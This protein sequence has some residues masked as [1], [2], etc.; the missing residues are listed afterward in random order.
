MT[1]DTARPGFP[2]HWLL[3]TPCRALCL[4]SPHRVTLKFRSLQGRGLPPSPPPSPSPKPERQLWELPPWNALLLVPHPSPGGPLVSMWDFLLVPSPVRP[5][6]TNS[7]PTKGQ[8]PGHWRSSGP[9][10]GDSSSQ[11]LDSC[12]V[13]AEAPRGWMC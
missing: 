11:L 5:G 4:D 2:K 7:D 3:V 1:K 9:S 13:T 6:G 8:D 10:K 12:H